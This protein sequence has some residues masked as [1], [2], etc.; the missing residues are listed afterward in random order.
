[1]STSISVKER[2]AL[3]KFGEAMKE[4]IAITQ[5]AIR[6]GVYGVSDDRDSIGE[7]PTAIPVA[8]DMMK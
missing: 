3:V 5:A 8:A 4:D 1:M 6:A 7:S 2:D